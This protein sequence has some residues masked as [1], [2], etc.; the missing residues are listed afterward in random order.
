MMTAFIQQSSI[1][2]PST[3]QSGFSLIE[4]MIAMGLSIAI[5][6]G[7]TQFMLSS[8]STYDFN[9]EQ[10]RVQENG[11]I[12]LD[13]IVKDIR[14]AGYRNPD[15]LAIATTNT[16]VPPSFLTTACMSGA[17]WA[18]CTADDVTDTAGIASDRIAIQMDPPPDDG[19]EIDCTGTLVASATNIIANV[20]YVQRTNGISSLTCRSFNV[21]LGAWSS[22]AVPL[23]DGIDSMHILYGIADING[24]VTQYV[25]L[26]AVADFNT[27][28]AVRIAILVSSGTVT[29]TAEAKPRQYALLDSATLTI[30]DAGNVFT[31]DDQIRHI[32]STTVHLNNFE[33]Y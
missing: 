13:I 1:K 25:P 4:L 5:M 9:D 28:R 10:T 17:G 2:Q 31:A 19:S 3:R 21:D 16:F 18:N 24:N 11:R 26:A 15:N 7:V 30:P 27:V 20:Y 14:I 6:A 29:G 33:T 12:A 32:Y 8:R 22:A 23:V